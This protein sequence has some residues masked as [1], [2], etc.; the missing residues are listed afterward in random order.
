MC[1]QFTIRLASIIVISACFFFTD[2]IDLNAQYDEQIKLLSEFRQG[3][4]E[5]GTAVDIYGDYAVVSAP[6]ENYATGA[7]YV[8]Q[9][10]SDGGWEFLQRLTAVNAHEMAEYGSAVKFGKDFLVVAAGREDIDGTTRA[11]ALYVYELSADS[12]AFSQKLIASDFSGDAHLGAYPETIT[13][14][15]GGIIAGSSGKNGHQ[16]AIYYFKMDSDGE[17]VEQQLIDTPENQSDVGFG[18]AVSIDGNQLA[19]G[20]LNLNDRM[21]KVFIYSN[22]NDPDKWELVS[23]VSPSDGTSNLFFGKAVS[24]DGNHLAVGANA[25]NN[26]NPLASAVYIYSKD[27]NG[28]W[29]ET[30]KIST[31]DVGEQTFFGWSCI[32]QNNKLYISAP[33][34]YQYEPGNVMIYTQN[35]ENQW[36]LEEYLETQDSREQDFFGWDIAVDGNRLI[37][38]SPRHGFDENGEDEIPDSGSAYIFHS[39]ETT[40]VE[41]VESADS[42]I[43]V[44]PNPTQGRTFLK[45]I[46]PY[47]SWELFSADGQLLLQSVGEEI[48]FVSRDSGMYF[49]K[50]TL[51]SGEIVV[52]KI[53]KIE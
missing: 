37:V 22:E 35:E 39:D 16:G 47:A 34:I 6:R 7:A 24:I 49:L 12:F 1:V 53:L 18:R 28:Y 19:V 38:G 13:T 36:E 26:V 52:K 45:S 33:H 40:T 15:G 10:K 25:E 23:E 8:Y 5:Y 42:E 43:L 44:Y 20:A 14:F 46:E 29:I 3:R 41:F 51:N 50:I 31:Y 2:I 17:W 21:G 11:G 30:Q 4:A 32:L 9:Y 48:D 27:I